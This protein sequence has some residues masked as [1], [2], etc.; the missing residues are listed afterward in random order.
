[1]LETSALPPGVG[2]A[3]AG[4]KIG[5]SNPITP[6]GEGACGMLPGWGIL[7][8]LLL[9]DAYNG[10]NNLSSLAILWSVPLWWYGFAL[11]SFN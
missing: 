7:K 1:M 9:G 4:A 10:F 5:Y 11:F 8:G 2:E 3:D 6:E